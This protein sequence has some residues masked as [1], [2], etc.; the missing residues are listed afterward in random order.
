M[1]RNLNISQEKLM[2]SQTSQYHLKPH[3]YIVQENFSYTNCANTGYGVPMYL[4]HWDGRVDAGKQ[5]NRIQ[6]TF[7][8]KKK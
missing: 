5:F 4:Q 7:I 2:R 3:Y 1:L 6:Q 8:Q